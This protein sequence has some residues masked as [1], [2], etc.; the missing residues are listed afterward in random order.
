MERAAALGWRLWAA[1]A[2]WTGDR[3]RPP[4]GSP[5]KQAGSR[6]R[7][8]AVAAMARAC[9]G[10][11]LRGRGP[12]GKAF[13]SRR[14]GGSRRTNRRRAALRGAARLARERLARG[15]ACRL[16][17]ERPR[18]RARHPWPAAR[19][20]L[21]LA[22]LVGVLRAPAGTLL[23]FAGAR[24]RQVDT[25][26]PRLGKADCNRLLR[27]PCAMLT[28]A[29]F[30]NFLVHEFARLRARRLAGALVA[31]SLLYRSFIRHD[32]FS[33][34]AIVLCQRAFPRALCLSTRWH[35]A[36]SKS[37]RRRS[38]HRGVPKL[39]QKSRR[40]LLANP[41]RRCHT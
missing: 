29:D 18:Y 22:R 24:R 16:A 4:D 7:S 38:V 35:G 17:L 2:P 25:R 33:R 15:G 34:L 21:V 27:R 26:A 40:S 41:I 14:L 13:G 1:A 8:A 11:L 19:L 10:G 31:P 20:A 30:A 6:A 5:R 36:G 12:P 9:A 32:G 3:K 39:R 28:A 23:G 37:R